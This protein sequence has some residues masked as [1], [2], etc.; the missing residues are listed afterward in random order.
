MQL[1]DK[2]NN[3]KSES[4]LPRI[5]HIIPHSGPRNYL[6]EEMK[7]RTNDDSILDLKAHKIVHKQELLRESNKPLIFFYDDDTRH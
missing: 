7:N 1:I 3:K 5:H 2:L 6:C 4:G